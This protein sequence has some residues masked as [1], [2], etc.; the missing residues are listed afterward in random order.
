M[1]L[2]AALMRCLSTLFRFAN[3]VFTYKYGLIVPT[4]SSLHAGRKTQSPQRC[5]KRH[6]ASRKTQSPQRCHKRHHTCHHPMSLS[7]AKAREREREGQRAGRVSQSD[8][9][10]RHHPTGVNDGEGMVAASL[11]QDPAL[12]SRVSSVCCNFS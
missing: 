8:Q 10:L 4:I 3:R 1:S 9:H 12:D 2:D 5:H 6:H 11:S 7:H